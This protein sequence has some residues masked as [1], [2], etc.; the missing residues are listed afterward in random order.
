MRPTKIPTPKKTNVISRSKDE[1]GSFDVEYDF[2]GDG[3]TQS[4]TYS[5]EGSQVDGFRVIQPERQQDRQIKPDVVA[6][7]YTSKRPAP[8]SYAQYLAKSKIPSTRGAF[9][10]VSPT[11]VMDVHSNSNVRWSQNLSQTTTPRATEDN[12]DSILRK[13]YPASNE[14]HSE[15][16]SVNF[17]DEDSPTSDMRAKPAR[18]MDESDLMSLAYS[19]FIESV[20]AVVIQT[21][22]RRFLAKL[23]VDKI[24]V[25]VAAA[26]KYR[27]NRKRIEGKTQPV[28]VVPNVQSVQDRIRVQQDSMANTRMEY[29][30]FVFAAIRIQSVFRGWFVRDILK[31][32]QYCAKMIQKN[33]RSFVYR[34]QYQY[35]LFRIIIAQSVVRRFLVCRNLFA[36]PDPEVTRVLDFAATMIQARWRGFVAEM[37]YYQDYGHILIS[38]SVVRRWLAI[39]YCKAMQSS[40]RNPRKP[41]N[42]F[43]KQHGARRSFG[44]VQQKVAAPQI[45]KWSNTR[46][47]PWRQPSS[48]NAITP[49]PSTEEPRSA[50]QAQNVPTGMGSIAKRR[51]MFESNRLNTV[52]QE[53]ANKQKAAVEMAELQAMQR[54]VG[55]RT[56]PGTQTGQPQR[57]KSMSGRIQSQTN[58][59][60]GSDF[61][62]KTQGGKVSS[63]ETSGSV[64]TSDVETAVQ[65]NLKSTSRLLQGWRDREQSNSFDQRHSFDRASER[66]NEVEVRGS[67]RLSTIGVSKYL[68]GKTGNQ[69]AAPPSPHES[70][71]RLQKSKQQD[72]GPSMQEIMRSKRSAKESARIQQI[73]DVFTTVG[74]MRHVNRPRLNVS[75]PP[76]EL[77]RKYSSPLRKTNSFKAEQSPTQATNQPHWIQPSRSLDSSPKTERKLFH[78]EPNNEGDEQAALKIW[79]NSRQPPRANN[80]RASLPPRQ[81]L[82]GA[83]RRSIGASPVNE[84]SK[85]LMNSLGLNTSYGSSDMS[86]MENSP[87]PAFMRRFQ[88]VPASPIQKA[89]LF[90]AQEQQQSANTPQR[91]VFSQ[92]QI[93][94]QGERSQEVQSK[95]N[96]IHAIFEKVGLMQSVA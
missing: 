7:S 11:S 56:S 58:K 87:S 6:P 49:S 3:F 73:E 70:V 43:G 18:S 65:S 61:R 51:A 77:E 80:N 23:L 46:N 20:A 85:N 90:G 12:P 63:F 78:D 71:P 95:L 8:V 94:K 24:R 47:V 28:V 81:E 60:W 13:R 59:K 10:K 83:E 41:T 86:D 93:Q 31:I 35:D 30:L 88:K 50:N 5:Q 64:V 26:R 19:E 84:R 36:A 25:Q 69:M 92:F 4:R 33:A 34:N 29:Q 39:R 40:A 91:P 44:N 9:S 82:S 17:R 75:Q 45:S 57:A 76:P 22:V 66:S 67:N 79:R 2:Y 96:D 38:Q 74:L 42:R 14:Y 68:G 72:V 16:T 48:S 1:N 15:P 32:E 37:R 52:Q 62:P 21:T 53:E 54:K 89:N 27:Y 55:V